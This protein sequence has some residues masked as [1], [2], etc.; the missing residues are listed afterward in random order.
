MSV[1]HIR[2]PHMTVHGIH[3][4]QTSQPQHSQSRHPALGP[5]GFTIEEVE[6]LVEGRL[7]LTGLVIAERA[8]IDRVSEGRGGGNL[9]L[10]E[11]CLLG[12]VARDCTYVNSL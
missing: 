2:L 5:V 11:H 12:S 8:M 4:Q 1:N 3:P 6:L 7:K 10:D 9:K